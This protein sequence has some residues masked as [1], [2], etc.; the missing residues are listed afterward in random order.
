LGIAELTDTL[1]LVHRDI[2]VTLPVAAAIGSRGL[3]PIVLGHEV[4]G[5]FPPGSTSRPVALLDCAPAIMPVSAGPAAL[6][7]FASRLGPVRRCGSIVGPS[8]AAIGLWERLRDTSPAWGNVRSLRPCQPLLLL[9]RDPAVIADPRGGVVSARH[10]QAY[11]RSAEAM[12]EE[13]L[14]VPPTQPGGYRSHVARLM[15]KGHTFGIVDGDEVVFKTDVTVTSRQFCQIGGVWLT[16]RLRG[17]GFSETALAGVLTVIRRR[18]PNV[19][20]Y[21]NDYNQPALALYR[22]L[23]FRQ[24]GEYASILY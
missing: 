21:V 9:D 15:D 5:W 7:D 20:L 3:D 17:H 22:R 13:E 4:W 24:V 16:P 18:W 14:G 2:A 8:E 11:L 12:Y 6:D 19:T 1:D 10:L 23:G